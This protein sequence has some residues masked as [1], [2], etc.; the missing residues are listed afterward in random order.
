MINFIRGKRR[1]QEDCLENEERISRLVFTFVAHANFRLHILI[2]YVRDNI[3]LH[4]KCLSSFLANEKY[5]FEYGFRFRTVY[6]YE[7][8]FICDSRV[9]ICSTISSV[10]VSYI[11]FAQIGTILNMSD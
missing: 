10:I 2:V 5:F 6:E 9:V 7:S 1:Y 3:R 11:I 8:H 4:F